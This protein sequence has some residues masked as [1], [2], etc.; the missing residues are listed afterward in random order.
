MGKDNIYRI[1]SAG[2]IKDFLT[3]HQDWT[4]EG[5]RLKVHFKLLNFETAVIVMNEV[6]K[7]ATRMDH[8]PQ[9]TNTFNQLG[10]S[11]CTHGVGD[12]VTS[13]DIALATEIAGIVSKLQ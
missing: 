4:F 6:A 10:F 9:M 5:D 7:V 2:E 13:Y 8:H 12:K 3:T 11:L 1:S